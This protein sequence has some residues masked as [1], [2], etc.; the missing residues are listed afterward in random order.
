LAYIRTQYHKELFAEIRNK[1]GR[2]KL[3]GQA[4]K[5]KHS[6]EYIA[7]RNMRE[8]C[9]NPKRAHY[10]DYGGRGIKV[11][12]SWL[13]SFQAFYD[14]VGS[15]P[16]PEYSL[17]RIDNNGNYEPENCKWTTKREQAKNRRKKFAIE[18]FSNSVLQAEFSRRFPDPAP[19]GY[20]YYAAG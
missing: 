12:D 19:V 8:R 17:D 20:E 6:S 15:K 2:P 16:G 4:T 13:A 1:N 18:N 10:S 14:D 3:H 9:N 11:C 5:K 7:W